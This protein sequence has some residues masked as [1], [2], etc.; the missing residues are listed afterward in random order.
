[1]SRSVYKIEE[2]YIKSEERKVLY[3]YA[4]LS[5]LFILLSIMLFYL[6]SDKELFKHFLD[7]LA[8]IFAG[9]KTSWSITAVFIALY[10]FR[11]M[12]VRRLHKLINELTKAKKEA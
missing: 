12:E 8:D 6:S 7:K 4:F 11:E 2:L 9:Q 10:L 3:K 1:M 5:L